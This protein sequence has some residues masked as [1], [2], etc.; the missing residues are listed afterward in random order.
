MIRRLVTRYW[1]LLPLLILVIVLLDR[2]EQPDVIQTEETIDM[3][4]TQSDYYLSEFRT[5]KFGV[6]G[7]IEY[8]VE[9]DILAHYPDDDRSEITRPKV[10]LRRE[11]ALWLVESQS[12]RF[13]P[14]PNLFTL[15][16]DVTMQRQLPGA[17]SATITMTTQSLRIATEANEVETDELVEV[18]APTWRLQAKGLRAAID[19]GRLSLLSEVQGRYEIPDV[20]DN[21]TQQ[22]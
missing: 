4:Q 1:L 15:R 22:D 19:D 16:G 7:T 8:I 5:R 11:S 17:D 6:D 14:A 21:A 13:D 18:R 9:G 20:S 3:R 10:E 2:V 12:G